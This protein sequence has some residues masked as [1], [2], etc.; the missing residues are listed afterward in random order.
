MS[1]AQSA[2]MGKGAAEV[3]GEETA[4]GANVLS[5]NKLSRLPS[6]T[7]TRQHHQTIVNLAKTGDNGPLDFEGHLALGFFREKE[8]R[9]SKLI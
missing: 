1:D 4:L 3:S 5:T 9:S 6:V 7:S 2:K 8:T